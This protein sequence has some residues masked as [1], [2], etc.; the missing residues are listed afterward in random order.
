MRIKITTATKALWEETNPL[1]FQGE[2]GYETDTRK[3]KIGVNPEAHWKDI[4]YI[5]STNEPMTIDS[6]IGLS[7]FLQNLS[8]V[9][10]VHKIGDIEN[11]DWRL[12]GMSHIEHQHQA[13]D[14][15]DF[16]EYLKNKILE[17]FPSIAHL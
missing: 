1:I 6:V 4:P 13:S 12:D 14:I 3:L 5:V 15:I 16:D 17:L 2:L 7:E 9:D 11:L 10:H 8:H